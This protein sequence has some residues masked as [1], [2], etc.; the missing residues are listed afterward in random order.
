MKTLLTLFTLAAM[1]PGLMKGYP[2]ATPA[3]QADVEKAIKLVQAG[4]SNDAQAYKLVE[5]AARKG[6]RAALFLMGYFSY[7]GRGGQ[8]RDYTKA[9][10]PLTKAADLGYPGALRLLGAMYF[11]AEGAPRDL[12]RGYAYIKLAEV[13][14]DPL[15]KR[16]SAQANNSLTRENL[17]TAHTQAVAWV[18]RHAFQ[19]A[20]EQKRLVGVLDAKDAFKKTAPDTVVPVKVH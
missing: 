8:Q 3:V 19:D 10:P 7:F 20:A 16:W 5:P 11:N 4:T 17:A 18:K 1:A 12:P 9:L 6:N 13:M 14:G 15:A 2:Q